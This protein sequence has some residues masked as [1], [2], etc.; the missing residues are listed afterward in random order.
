MGWR[1]GRE[2]GGRETG[3]A[4]KATVKA[5][6]ACSHLVDD[7]VYHTKLATRLRGGTLAP[8]NEDAV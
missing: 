5:K 2:T 7:P 3:T 1:K 6:T 4:N 8:L